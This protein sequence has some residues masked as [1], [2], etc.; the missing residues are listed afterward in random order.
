VAAEGGRVGSSMANEIAR[1][2][3]MAAGQPRAVHASPAFFE[4]AI[5]MVRRPPIA[6]RR[7]A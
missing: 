3:R 7:R 1:K 5:L 2:L 6:R 4:L